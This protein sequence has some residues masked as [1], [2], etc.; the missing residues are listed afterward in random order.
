[1]T[2]QGKRDKVGSCAV[3]VGCFDQDDRIASTIDWGSVGFEML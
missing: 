2:G 1:M 3:R